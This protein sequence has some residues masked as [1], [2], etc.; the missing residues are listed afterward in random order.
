MDGNI[1]AEPEQVDGTGT[2][3]RLLIRAG[4]GRTG[5]STG[6]DM[7]IQRARYFGRRVKPLDG[8]LRS[9]TLSC[10][11]PT[12]AE[13]GTSI[14]DGASAPKS[15][16]LADIKAWLSAELDEMVRTGI[17]RVLDLS[18]GDR[19]MQ[20]Y[21]RDLALMQFCE[22]F[23]IAV[24][25]AVYLGPDMED[26]RHATQLLTSGELKCERTLL[27]LNEGVIR[28]GQSTTGAFDAIMAQ[29][30]FAKL[31]DG[32][33]RSMFMRRLTCMPLLREQ[34]LRFYDLL[35]RLP[36]S[37]GASVSPTLQH[38]TKTWLLGFERELRKSEV[39]DWLP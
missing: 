6:L 28:L 10:L 22:D 1:R 25:V 5:G 19:V 29:P 34:R 39:V 11:Y 30:E 20:E 24:T 27:V 3:P 8:D 17:S 14:E 15:D 13:D 7:A 23:G 38:M 31:T 21:V 35:D 4:R 18:G 9:R 37:V 33:A 26:F 12:H 36:G 32:G 16:E 2:V